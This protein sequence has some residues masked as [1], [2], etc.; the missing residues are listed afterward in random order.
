M[1]KHGMGRYIIA[2]DRSQTQKAPR[3]VCTGNV[4][5]S[6]RKSWLEH[7]TQVLRMKAALFNLALGVYLVRLET[8]VPEY[9]ESQDS[10]DPHTVSQL[11]SPS[12]QASIGR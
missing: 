3:F 12:A 9:P 2:L 8:A 6:H 1:R 4:E 5:E 11:R 7:D 10:R